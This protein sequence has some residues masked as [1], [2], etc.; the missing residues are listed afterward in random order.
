MDAA[1]KHLAERA[2]L[3]AV[4]HGQLSHQGVRAR[5]WHQRRHRKGRAATRAAP[6]GW[7]VARLSIAIGL[8]VAAAIGLGVIGN[9]TAESI[10]QR[11]LAQ[12]DRA[13]LALGFG[14]KTVRIEG[15]RHVLRHVIETALQ[16]GPLRSQLTFDAAAARRRLLKIGWIK[17][18]DIKRVYPDGLIVSIEERSPVAIWRRGERASLIDHEGRVLAAVA[19]D[20][21]VGLPL[22]SGA[23]A[24]LAVGPLLRAISAYPLLFQRVAAAERVE[25]RR[26]T[27]VLSNGLRVELPADSL[28]AAV[29][30]LEAHRV[31]GWLDR[32][33][34]TLDLRVHGQIVIRRRPQ[35]P[36]TRSRGSGDR[37]VV[38]TSGGQPR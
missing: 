23:G 4:A 17:S 37:V 33:I 25:D 19:R 21:E 10:N 32:S 22:V 24:H 35:Q 30:R 16:V 15:H 29:T 1:H 34:A 27:L 26:W 31:K 2:Q 12:V 20:A 36:L 8:L 7:W 38:S 5:R 13:G 11:L 14:I 28:A 3:A 18:V 6:G 9:G